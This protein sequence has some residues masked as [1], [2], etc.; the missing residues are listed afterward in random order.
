MCSQKPFIVLILVILFFGATPTGAEEPSNSPE[1]FCISSS[2]ISVPSRP[3]VTSATDTT[4]CGVVEL[5]YGLE[6]QWPGN[7]ANRDDLSGGLRLGLTQ[8]LDFHWSSSDFLHVMNGDGNRTGFGDT[9]LGLRYR[10][11]RQT[12]HRPSMGLA[13]QAKLPS[14][15][16]VLGLGSGQ[17]DH[18]P[19]FLVSKDIHPFHLDFNLMPLLAGRP[20]GSGFDHNVGFALSASAP[21]TRR[22]GVVGEGY[23]YTTLN[24]NNPAFASTMLGFTYQVEPRLILDAGLDVGVTSGSPRKRVF[25]GVTYAVAN[26]YSWIRPRP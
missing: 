8:N 26:V 5:E 12:K 22:L 11:L 10:F 6:R 1:T 3:T 13:Y 4:Q 2:V 18:A 23:G 15:S 25:V 17:V 19:S 24:Q 14:A 16:V 21:L 20:T 9:W 7:G